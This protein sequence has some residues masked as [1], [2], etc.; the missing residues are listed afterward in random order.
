MKRIAL[1][2][3]CLSVGLLST[4]VGAAEDA[5]R[6]R[7]ETELAAP[8]PTPQLRTT[9]ATP[10]QPVFTFEMPKWVPQLGLDLATDSPRFLRLTDTPLVD[11]RGAL[12]QEL[13]P[14]ALYSNRFHA[15]STIENSILSSPASMDIV[16]PDTRFLS[17][18]STT[19][20][21]IRVNP[22]GQFSNR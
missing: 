6:P 10:I 18:E 12:D 7:I 21:M 5:D 13:S 20:G 1:Q 15:P 11:M 16:P 8:A 4:A 2:I 3:V 19:V 17:G 9:S 22:V 14:L